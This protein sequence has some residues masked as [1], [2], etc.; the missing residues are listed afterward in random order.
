MRVIDAA[1][2][3]VEQGPYSVDAVTPSNRGAFNGTGATDDAGLTARYTRT[4]R[5]RLTVGYNERVRI[6]GRLLNSAGRPIAGARLN[7]F[8]R[9]LRQGARSVERGSAI[10]RVDGVYVTTVSA[11][12]SR[13]IQVGWRSHVNDGRFQ[14]SAYVTLKARA[15][16]R[17]SV[18]PRRAGLGRTVILSGRVRGTIP[19]RGVALIFQGRGSGGSYSTF[20]DGRASRSGRFRVRYTFRSGASRGRAFVFR[21]KLRGDAGFPYAQGYSNRVRVRVL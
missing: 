9:D 20:A 21:V 3:V 5:T 13:L 8:T 4:R 7:I 14:E 16:A 12:A 2:N 19:S 11:G 6:T 17:L 1:E 18:S 15:S 10:T